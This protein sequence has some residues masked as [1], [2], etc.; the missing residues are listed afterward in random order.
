MCICDVSCYFRAPMRASQ[1]EERSRESWRE[2]DASRGSEDSCKTDVNDQGSVGHFQVF[3]S[4]RAELEQRSRRGLTELFLPCPPSS[5]SSPITHLD[6]QLT[7]YTD[8]HG[9]RYA[10]HRCTTR[11]HRCSV[12]R[13]AHLRRRAVPKKTA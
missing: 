6:C 12:W 9:T 4:L 10:S 2:S 11:F 7:T 5:P 13:R 8:S 3:W 1:A